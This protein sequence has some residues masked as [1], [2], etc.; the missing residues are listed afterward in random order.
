M[1]L[2]LDLRVEISRFTPCD[3]HIALL[4][5]IRDDPLL[6]SVDAGGQKRF[7]LLCHFTLWLRGP[8]PAG[9]EGLL[10]ASFEG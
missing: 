2:S 5:C 4:K 8:H 1:T 10:K 9:E 3:H 7:S 6:L